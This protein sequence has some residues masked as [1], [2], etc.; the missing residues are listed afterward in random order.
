MQGADGERHV[1]TVLPTLDMKS[2]K[3]LAMHFNAG[4]PERVSRRIEVKKIWFSNLAMLLGCLSATTAF[5]QYPGAY[6]SL[7]PSAFPV[8]TQPQVN[9]QAFPQVPQAQQGQWGAA[10]KPGQAYGSPSQSYSVPGQLV[11]GV[12]APNFGAASNTGFANTGFANTGLQQNSSVQPGFASQ[13]VGGTQP[14]WFGQ[15]S[16]P[17]QLVGIQEGVN[18]VPMP[19]VPSNAIPHGISPVP[20]QAPMQGAQQSIMEHGAPMHQQTME[21]NHG[22][23]LSY[24]SAPSAPVMN[25]VYGQAI[26]PGCTSCG[27]A[28]LSESY[29][30]PAYSQNACGP[31]AYAAPFGGRVSN[32]A[33][34]SLFTGMPAEAKPFFGG[35]SVLLFHRVDDDNVNLVYDV[36]MPGNNLLGTQDARSGLMPGFEVFLGRYFNCGRNAITAS[37]WGLFPEDE[38]ASVT[39]D[40]GRDLRSRYQFTGVSMPMIGTYDSAPVYDWYDTTDPS[41]SGIA[42]RAQR[43]DRSSEFHNIEANLLGFM[44]GGAARS[45]YLPTAGTLFSGTRG[46][47]G[48]FGGGYGGGCGYCGGSGCGMCGASQGSCGAGGCGTGNCGD[49]YGGAPTRFATGPC[50]LTPGCG[51]RLNMTWLAGI[52]YFRFEDNLTYISSLTDTSFGNGN[53]DIYYNSNV[54][55]EL[56]GFQIGGTLNYCTGRR[57][58][59]YATTKMGIYGNHSRF[60][61]DLGTRNGHRAYLTGSPTEAYMISASKTDVAFL[62]EMGTGV[63]YRL[64]SKWSGNFGYRAIVASG[65]ATAVDQLPINMSHLGNAADFDNNA[66]L[67]LHG[68][69]LG[70]QYNY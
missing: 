13:S 36:N 8:H 12:P 11:G 17:F 42:S 57:A 46:A 66:A 63:N 3:R 34:G 19:A 21:H 59:L 40:G 14:G 1:F 65:V 6:G 29:G 47:R 16:A 49:C 48:G 5:G 32:Y 70:A 41:G 4:L 64:T 26:A 30:Y 67:I 33:R 24:Q 18:A 31:T 22:Q 45:F 7:A 2:D 43:I 27:T 69:N 28:P 68:V 50:C 58:S 20:M 15:R 61:S 23:A 25:P 44:T 38:M 54:V 35:G 9:Y 55:N 10:Q 62:G 37:Y 39:T 56:V 51:S 60:D 53:D 52:R